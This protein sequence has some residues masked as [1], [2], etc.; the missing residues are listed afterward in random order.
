[1]GAAVEQAA[2]AILREG[3][4]PEF[5]VD[6]PRTPFSTGGP[7]DT[8]DLPIDWTQDPFSARSWRFELHTLQWLDPRVDLAVCRDVALDWIAHNP[9]DASESE[10][11]WY[12]MAVGKRAPKI[13]YIARAA[14]AE[15]MLD[16]A[17]AAVFL[18]SIREH[19]DWLVDDANYQFGHNHGL[20]EDEGLLS[21]SDYASVLPEAETWRAHAF[22]RFEAS[23]R[24]TVDWRDALHLEHSPGYHFTI[25]N[26]IRRVAEISELPS[27]LRDLLARM[28]ETARWLVAPN[29]RL[30]QIGDTH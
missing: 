10:F 30:P 28:E 3:G 25:I 29:G 27:S 13:A 11:A 1:M 8:A 22:Q 6:V 24:E 19:G 26:M 7:P 20:F 17:Q 2:L 5:R 18:N 23:L 9:R 14:A 12:D 4:T 21:L 15:G 16:D